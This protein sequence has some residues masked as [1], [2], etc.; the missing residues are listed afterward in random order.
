MTA[1]FILRNLGDPP[2]ADV[3]ACM[4]EGFTGKCY[5]VVC[6]AKDFI[7]AWGPGMGGWVARLI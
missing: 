1:I 5:P 3:V 6:T 7:D 4:G 2:V